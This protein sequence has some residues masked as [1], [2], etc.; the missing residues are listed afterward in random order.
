[1][2]VSQVYSGF[3]IRSIRAFYH[4]LSSETTTEW[5]YFKQ[6]FL[7]FL[8]I[9]CDSKNKRLSEIL[10]KIFVIGFSEVAENLKTNY[11]LNSVTDTFNFQGFCLV[12]W[13]TNFKKHL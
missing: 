6:V 11:K 13:S 2:E 7:Q 8:E 5:C 1:M 4:K 9:Q 12:F 3:I 10:E